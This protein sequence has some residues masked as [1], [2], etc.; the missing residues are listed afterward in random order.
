M[1]WQRVLS[2]ALV[3]FVVLFLVWRVDAIRNLVTGTPA[4]KAA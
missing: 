3:V 4:A 1:S 2:I